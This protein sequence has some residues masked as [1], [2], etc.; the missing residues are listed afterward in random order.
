MGSLGGSQEGH[1]AARA[2]A[3]CPS[4]PHPP[5]RG[6][7]PRW[8]RCGSTRLGLA[9]VCALT[10]YTAFA[11]FSLSECQSLSLSTFESG[12]TRVI[13]FNLSLFSS[14]SLSPHPTPILF[15]DR[16]HLPLPLVLI[17]V[18]LSHCTCLFCDHPCL[19]IC[20]SILFCLTLFLSFHPVQPPTLLDPPQM[21]DR[22][23]EP[24]ILKTF[25][26]IIYFCV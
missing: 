7:T 18:S 9:Q 21:G 8:G 25:K 3:T 15:Y 4:P 22:I 13:F 19:S 20:L 6:Q 17:F 12:C 11:V 5:L 16:S 2:L 26:N 1:Q 10:R 23:Q 14:S 24:R